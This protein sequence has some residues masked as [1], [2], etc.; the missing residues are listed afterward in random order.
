MFL[1]LIVAVKNS[2]KRQ[3]AASPARP[4]AAGSRSSPARARSRDGIGT[5]SEF[6]DVVHVNLAAVAEFFRIEKVGRID[7]NHRVD[8]LSPQ[9]AIFRNPFRPVYAPFLRS[10]PSPN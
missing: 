2:M 1:F 7:I 4:I 5:S 10:F 9:M 8:S 3:A 6:M